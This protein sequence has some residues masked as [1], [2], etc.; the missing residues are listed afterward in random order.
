MDTVSV[1]IEQ[2]IAIHIDTE[3]MDPETIESIENA[4]EWALTGRDKAVT[5]EVRNEWLYNESSECICCP[6]KHSYGRGA[7]VLASDAKP[8][9]GND[10]ASHV[11]AALQR[12]GD[13]AELVIEI[14]KKA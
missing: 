5:I 9:T 1:I 8:I 10:V 14:R 7:V 13:S 4:L 2:A 6:G 11:S 3:G 12:F